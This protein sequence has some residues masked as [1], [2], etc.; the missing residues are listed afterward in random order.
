MVAG[1]TCVQACMCVCGYKVLFYFFT[2]KDYIYI[3]MCSHACICMCACRWACVRVFVFTSVCICAWK[4]HLKKNVCF[5]MCVHG[6]AL[7]GLNFVAGL[8]L[9]IL[10]N[11][12]KAFWLLDTLARHILPGDYFIIFLPL[13]F[14][15]LSK[16]YVCNA[17][18]SFAWCSGHKQ[19]VI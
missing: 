7:Q 17:W 4:S 19:R 1:Y 8:I 13:L 14:A 18:L 9:L 2:L 5:C 6:H 3:C 11:E 10:R 15:L 16:A 12:E